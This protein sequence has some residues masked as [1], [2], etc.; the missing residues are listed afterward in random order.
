M[1]TPNF[2]TYE[3]PSCLEK[4]FSLSKKAVISFYP[5]STYSTEQN[6]LLIGGERGAETTYVI[7]NP[8]I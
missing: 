2:Y 4:A 8:H 7:K 1:A 5:S 3:M 6:P